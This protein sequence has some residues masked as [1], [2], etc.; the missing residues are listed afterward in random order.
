MKILIG[1]Y[2]LGSERFVDI[3]GFDDVL[4]TEG[5]YPAVVDVPREKVQHFFQHLKKST[6][7]QPFNPAPQSQ[8][9]CPDEGFCHHECTYGC[10]RVA[11]V[12]PLS[13]GI[14]PDGWPPEVVAQNGEN[15]GHV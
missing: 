14:Y 12:G 10:W 8:R 3:P 2:H 11:H 1:W 9:M 5:W 13:G 15:D 7:V 6:G 4:D